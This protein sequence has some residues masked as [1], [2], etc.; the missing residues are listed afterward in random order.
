MS[1]YQPR[2]PSVH[3]ASDFVEGEGVIYTPRYGPREDGVVTS[4]S[5]TMVFVRYRAAQVYGT[6]TYPTDLVKVSDVLMERS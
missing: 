2:S 1:D 6:A 3:V 5:D 4:V